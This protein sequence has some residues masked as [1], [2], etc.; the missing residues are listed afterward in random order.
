MRRPKTVRCGT[1]ACLLISLLYGVLLTYQPRRHHSSLAFIVDITHGTISQ[2]TTES[3]MV[4]RSLHRRSPRR[5]SRERASVTEPPEDPRFKAFDV[6]TNVQRPA[7]NAPRRPVD[8]VS[9]DELSISSSGD[10]SD[11]CGCFLDGMCVGCGDDDTFYSASLYDEEGR[12]IDED[13]LDDRSD[14]P[15]QRRLR[16]KNKHVVRSRVRDM[17]DERRPQADPRGESTHIPSSSRRHRKRQTEIMERLESPK[18]LTKGR[19]FI[20]LSPRFGRS[21]VQQEKIDSRQ[22]DISESHSIDEFLRLAGFPDDREGYYDE[23][24]DIRPVNN[25]RKSFKFFSRNKS[26]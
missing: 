25:R 1:I 10:E 12:R 2:P 24:H 15:D 3:T 18:P 9:F 17:S 22:D 6:R 19:S 13:E 14:Q 4:R 8:L 21:K 11:D 16:N 26:E 23:R 20:K 7:A 5:P